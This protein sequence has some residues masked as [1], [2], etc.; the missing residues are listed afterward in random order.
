MP[1]NKD[2]DLFKNIG[3]K[4]KNKRK[5]LNISQ[6]KLSEILDVEYVQIWRYETG[7]I[8]IPLDYLAKIAGFLNTD[9]NYFLSDISSG[10]SVEKEDKKLENMILMTKDIFKSNNNDLMFAA[11][12]CISSIHSVIKKGKKE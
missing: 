12:K 7:K 6:E 10:K 8:K 2:L 9:I 5:E 3:L 1:R 11:Y 4:I